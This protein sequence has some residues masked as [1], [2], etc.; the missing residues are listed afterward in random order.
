MQLPREGA[1]SLPARLLPRSDAEPPRTATLA[2]TALPL[3]APPP[4]RCPAPS[5]PPLRHVAR[6]LRALLSST[7]PGAFA[8]SP[9]TRPPLPHPSPP[10]APPPHRAHL[11][12]PRRLTRAQTRHR[13]CHL[14]AFED[15]TST[16]LAPGSAR[17]P[18]L[19]RHSKIPHRPRSTPLEETTRH[20]DDDH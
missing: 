17:V 5:R 18:S 13:T 8:P 16:P 10:H 15:P 14:R 7:L 1:L 12:I 6:R 9:P 19:P 4:A 11:K 3:R 2:S 20:Q